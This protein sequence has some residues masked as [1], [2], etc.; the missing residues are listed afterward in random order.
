MKSSIKNFLSNS[1]AFLV[2]IF[3]TLCLVILLYLPR[4]DS[5]WNFLRQAPF[6]AGIYFW[7]S[8]RPDAF[9]FISAFILGVFADVLGGVMLGINIFSFLVL[10]LVSIFLSER[11]NIKRFSYSWLLFSSALLI[12]M[13]FKGAIISV[14]FRQL[15]PLNLLGIEF[16]L[17]LAVYPLLARVYILIER[18]FIHLEE[19]YEKVQS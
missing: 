19:R 4:G 9:N 13:L 18:R 11:F 10:Y 7:Q 17:T 16:L 2:P 14:F 12:T 3:S 15:L 8:Q 6:Y 1:A 5:Y